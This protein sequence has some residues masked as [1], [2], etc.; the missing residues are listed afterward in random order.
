MSSGQKKEMRARAHHLKPVIRVGQRGM[1]D[2]VIAA[3]DQA[4]YDHELTKVQ[5][6]TITREA[7]QGVIADL[8]DSLS[9]DLVGLVGA[10]ATL[11]RPRP[12]ERDK[13]HRTIDMRRK[14]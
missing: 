11:Y 9:A 3:I 7:R 13:K 6:R 1:T 10:V 8:C 5:L 14:R 12:D 2:S 4:L